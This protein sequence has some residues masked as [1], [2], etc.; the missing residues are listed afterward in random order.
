ML[1]LTSHT[2]GKR[3]LVSFSSKRSSSLHTASEWLTSGNLS[4]CLSLHRNLNF[5][6]AVPKTPAAELTALNWTEQRSWFRAR[7]SFPKLV[8]SSQRNGSRTCRCERV[9]YGECTF[10]SGW[11]EMIYECVWGHELWG[12]NT[13]KRKFETALSADVNRNT[14]RKFEPCPSKVTNFLPSASPNGDQF[15]QQKHKQHSTA[16]SCCVVSCGVTW[17]GSNVENHSP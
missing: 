16:G 4:L 15:G 17:T 1:L 10:L 9:R 5:S 7:Q 2:A 12:E 3:K 11:C 14:T 8:F 6:Q 13:D